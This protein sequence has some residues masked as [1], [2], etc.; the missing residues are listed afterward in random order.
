MG[1]NGGQAPEIAALLHAAARGNRESL[2]QLLQYYQGRL[3]NMVALR[4]DPR[5]HSRVDASDVVQEALLEADRRWVDY[6]QNPALDF[7]IW[8]RQLAVQKLIDLH[9]HH[10]AQK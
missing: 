3:K 4:L 7:Y 2:S 6:V 9:R 5:L 1:G 10:L 8:L